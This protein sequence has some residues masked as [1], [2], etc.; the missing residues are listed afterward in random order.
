MMASPVA[1][2]R[3]AW[4]EPY[5]MSESGGNIYMLLQQA[6][7]MR[8]TSPLAALPWTCSHERFTNDGICQFETPAVGDILDLNITLR[9]TMAN[10]NNGQIAGAGLPYVAFGCRGP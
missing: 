9:F 6:F 7:G 1:P 8:S 4:A 3:M 5:D 10:C 2:N